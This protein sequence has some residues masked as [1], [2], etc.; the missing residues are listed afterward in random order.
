MYTIIIQYKDGTQIV[1]DN[2]IKF[3]MHEN[4]AIDIFEHKIPTP[5]FP[6]KAEELVHIITILKVK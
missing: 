2:I 5:F 6:D 1:L 4:G 3:H